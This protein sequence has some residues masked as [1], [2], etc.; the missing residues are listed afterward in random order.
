MGSVNKEWVGLTI[1]CTIMAAFLGWSC[2]AVKPVVAWAA[3]K[4]QEVA[5]DKGDSELF[6]ACTTVE[7]FD[8]LMAKRKAARMVDGGAVEGG[9]E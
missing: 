6:A 3:D 2:A 8:A 9:A 4:C 1:T 7:A 5:V